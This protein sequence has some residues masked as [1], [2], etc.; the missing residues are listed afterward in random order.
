MYIEWSVLKTVCIVNQCKCTVLYVWLVGWNKFELRELCIETKLLHYTCIFTWCKA[1]IAFRL[2]SSYGHQ[3]SRCK[4]ESSC[5]GFTNMHDVSCKTLKTRTRWTVRHVA[6]WRIV[7]TNFGLYSALRAWSAMVFRL[8]WQSKFTITKIFWRVGTMPAMAVICHCSKVRGAGVN[9]TEV[10]GNDGP[11]MALEVAGGNKGLFCVCGWV[12]ELDRGDN[13]PGR[14]I[15]PSWLVVK[16]KGYHREELDHVADTVAAAAEAGKVVAVLYPP[17]WVLADSGGLPWN[18]GIPSR[19]RRNGRNLIF[20]WIPPDSEWNSNGFRRILNGI[21][22]DSTG[23][24][25]EFQ[26]IPPDSEWNSNGLTTFMDGAIS[27]SHV[28]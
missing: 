28:M 5:L 7:N 17:T 20:W 2:G 15:P 6:C 16:D 24:W 8:R 10:E 25:M 12:N 22:M 1:W 4:N 21:P 14:A 11:A 19:I 13:G 9:G 3:V 23:F 27:V 26:W 18:V